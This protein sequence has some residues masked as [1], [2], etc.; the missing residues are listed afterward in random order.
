MSETTDGQSLS[1]N[2]IWFPEIADWL[3][4]I[5]TLL[6]FFGLLPASVGQSGRSPE[7]DRP[8]ECGTF[9]IG[10]S[11]IGGCD[12]IGRPPAPA[13]LDIARSWRSNTR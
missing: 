11:A 4:K 12:G 5:S 9:T 8:G 1:G 10:V 3:S 13:S 6:L 7:T 2:T